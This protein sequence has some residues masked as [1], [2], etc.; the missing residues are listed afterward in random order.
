MPTEL[1]ALRLIHIVCGIFWAGSGLFT[2]LFLAPALASSG[3]N[4]GQVFAALGR[5]KLF[6]VLPVAALLTIGSGARLM[7]LVSGGFGPTY[8]GS[9]SGQAFASSGACAVLAFLL[10]LLVGRPAAVRSAALAAQAVA[11]PEDDRAALA[12]R[13]A[14][15]RRIGGI[16]STV[17]VTLLMLA[18]AGMSVARYV[19]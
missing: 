6:V 9:A 19:S 1:L 15:V 18:A 5:R 16:A 7:Y 2:A 10:S 17:A 8:M 14:R 11:A 12:R 13:A 3:A 4:A